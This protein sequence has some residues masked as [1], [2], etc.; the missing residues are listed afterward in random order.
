MDYDRGAHNYIKPRPYNLTNDDK[1]IKFINY[2]QQYCIGIIDIVNSTRETSTIANPYKLRKYYSLFL[3][4]MSS[5]INNCNGKVVK[6]IG[7]SLFFY[8]PDTC[9]ETNELAFH[10]VFECGMRMLSSS[11]VIDSQLYENDLHSINYRICMNYG[12]VEVAMSDNSNEVDLFGSIVNEC[13]KMNNVVT[14]KELWIGEKLY[15]KARKSRFINNYAI[16][17]VNLQ[18]NGLNTVKAGKNSDYLYS[19]SILD[20]IQREKSMNDYREAQNTANKNKLAKSED[21]SSIN[22]LLIDDEEDILYTF[23]NLLNRQCYK[24]KAFS[25]SIEA[26]QHFTERNPYCYDLILMDIRMPGINGIQL[27]HKFRAINPHV[28]ILFISAL[29]VVAELVGSIPGISIQQIV[30]KP[31]EPEDFILKIKST[32]RDGLI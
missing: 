30:R 22:I 17:K 12:E 25:D 15:D 4:T 23:Q 28:K 32:I 29:D 24:V 9:I 19:V 5:V 31:I 26:F 21:N 16:N 7:D 11:S 18:N 6:T 20:E 13:A 10:D 1:Q 8:F 2:T 27:Y 14:S 3:N